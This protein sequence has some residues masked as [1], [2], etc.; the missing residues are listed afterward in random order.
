[1]EYAKG[2]KYP[3]QQVRLSNS[4]VRLR[5]QV[6]TKYLEN[7]AFHGLDD[8]VVALSG[9]CNCERNSTRYARAKSYRPRYKRLVIS[10]KT[11]HF[12]TL[13]IPDLLL[14]LPFKGFV[15][16][17]GKGQFLKLAEDLPRAATVSQVV[18]FLNEGRSKNQILTSVSQ[19]KPQLIASLSFHSQIF[20]RG[21]SLYPE[22]D[23]LDYIFDEKVSDE[24]LIDAVSFLDR[25]MGDSLEKYKNKNELM[26]SFRSLTMDA[27][28]QINRWKTASFDSF[29]KER[30][31]FSRLMGVSHDSDAVD[32][33]AKNRVLSELSIFAIASLSRRPNI[34][35]KAALMHRVGL[36]YTRDTTL[37]EEPFRRLFFDKKACAKL[38]RFL[39]GSSC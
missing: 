27:S 5:N 33:R 38:K 39:E 11:A 29:I 16:P 35:N 28:H 8:A 30:T 31:L 37:F 1:V 26:C 10:L 9:R 7:M 6:P 19:V 36:S 23:V 17:M 13:H 15:E 21:K 25:E 20:L 24:Q 22:A 18:D 2:V 4:A 14:D 12:S 32:T 34:K 3:P